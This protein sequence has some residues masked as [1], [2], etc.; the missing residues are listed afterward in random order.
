MAGIKNSVFAGLNADYS[1]AAGPNSTTAEAN[2]LV[3]NGKMWIGSTALNVGGTHINVGSITSPGSTLTIGYS[4]PNITIDVNG[5]QVGETITGNTGGAISPVAGNWNILGLGEPTFDGT[6]GTLSLSA[7]R[8]AKFIV[9]PTVNLGTQQTITA[10]LAAASS[11]DT[12]FIR[13][14]TYTENIT[15]KAGVNLTAFDGDGYNPNVKIIG[16]VTA[17]YTGTATL[18]GICLQTNSAAFLT[19]SGS[20]TGTLYLLNCNLLATNNNGMAIGNA[21]FAI[22]IVNSFTTTSAGRSLFAVTATAGMEFD[23]CRLQ[24]SDGTSSTISGNNINFINCTVGTPVTTSS[25]GTLAYRNCDVFPT[26]N[27]SCFT[28]GGTGSAL[29]TNCNLESGSATCGTVGAGTTVTMA[30]CALSSSSTNVISGTGTLSYSGIS[31]YGSSTQFQSTLTLTLR[32]ATPANATSGFI[33]T[34]TGTNTTPTWQAVG[35]GVLQTLTGDTGTATAVAGNIQIAGGPGV[36]T[37]ASGA[38]VTIN[39]VVFTDTT[40]ATLAVDNGYFATAAGTYPLPATAVQGELIYVVCDTAGAVVLD[41]PAANFIRV[42][43]QITSSG[44]TITSNSIGDSVTLRYRLATLT[45]E[46][47]SVIGTWTAA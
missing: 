1:Q 45:W 26:T 7:P 3:T 21:N 13:P 47:T 30:T 42:G 15:L 39:S 37:S 2:G 14:G 4:S 46:A 28:T 20:T 33:W 40:A 16:N 17:N 18:S 12:I 24:A 9:S 27:T 23:N 11:G 22:Y 35:G 34:S 41:A 43:A 31:F 6:A 5:S 36:T 32:G 38:V 25:T 29:F 19:C 10:A 8:T 44:G